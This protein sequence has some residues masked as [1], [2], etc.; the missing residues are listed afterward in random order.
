[1]SARET[2]E[3]IMSFNSLVNG[4]LRTCLID[5]SKVPY[6][7]S[8][9][10]A[11][12]SCLDHFVELN[13]LAECKTLDRYQGVGVSI[14]ASKICA[15]DVDHCFSVPFDQN[16]GDDRFRNCYEIFKDCGY[17]EF[18]FSGTGLRIL[19]NEHDFENYSDKYYT[20]NSKNKIEFY[21]PN[22]GFRYVSLTGR[23]I[24]DNDFSS[25]NSTKEIYMFLDRF[26]QRPI[27]KGS[28]D[29]IQRIWPVNSSQNPFID[30]KRKLL[31]DCFFQDLWFS[32]APGFGRDE[33]ERDYKILAS[34][35]EITTDKK[36]LREMF[37]S[38]P[39]FKSKDYQHKT[40]W[41]KNNHWYF[42][43]I[44]RNIERSFHE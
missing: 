34:L 8:G 33:S 25:I 38:S 36:T 12:T 17:I 43:Y 11:K 19:L 29:K 1:M 9:D 2:L 27:S 4:H 13:K 10:F 5:E 23:C 14:Q 22:S 39:Y 31:K 7:T 16:S 24:K 30:L 41:E 6:Q 40:K 20:K 18:S 32:K 3:A 44:C 28:E 35:Y 15:V 42:Y 26:M 21:Y 37:E